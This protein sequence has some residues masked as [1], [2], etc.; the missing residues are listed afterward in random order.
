MGRFSRVVLLK[1]LF[2]IIGQS[3]VT[4]TMCRKTFDKIHVIQAEGPLLRSKLRRASCL[5]QTNRCKS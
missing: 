1:A 4:L 5:A 3:H 2:Q